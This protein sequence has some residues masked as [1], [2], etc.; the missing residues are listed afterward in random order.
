MTHFLAQLAERARGTAPRV[1]PLIVSRFARSDLSGGNTVS[2]ITTEIEAPAAATPASE[3]KSAA[4]TPRESKPVPPRAEQTVV[5]NTPLSP[6][7]ETLHAGEGKTEIVREPLLVRL[8]PKHSQPLVVRQTQI[9][10]QVLEHSPG[11][12]FLEKRPAKPR[13][14]RMKSQIPAQ[15]LL[16]REHI[17]FSFAPEPRYQAPIVRVTIGRID[18]RATPTPAPQRHDAV[19]Q[20]GPTL[21]LDAYLK[22]RKEGRR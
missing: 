1:K 2:E 3:S 5:E 8:I 15:Q 7:A 12:A 16:Q 10:R 19:R 6:P 17:A 14:R 13:T 22:E 18:V 11:P 9:G 20:V 21:T 4:A